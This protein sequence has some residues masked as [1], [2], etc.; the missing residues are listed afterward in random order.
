M[1]ITRQ[2]INESYQITSGWVRDFANN[3]EKNADFL[4]NV[5]DVFKKRNAPKTID[6]K[7]ADI[8]ERVGYGIV[9]ADK[10]TSLEN[11]KEAKSEDDK[12]CACCD[13]CSANLSCDL[14][15]PEKDD[16]RAEMVR[17]MSQ[18]IDYITDFLSD[19]PELSSGAILDHCRQHPQL[20]WNILSPRMDHNKLSD[21]INSKIKNRSYGNELVKYISHDVTGSEPDDTTPEFMRGPSL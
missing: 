13:K 19:R 4:S 9:K 3:L 14:K 20:S 16:N 2:E 1:K 18:L 8:K 7:M 11:I 10:P 12:G 15:M 21:F 5:K 17:L 6:E